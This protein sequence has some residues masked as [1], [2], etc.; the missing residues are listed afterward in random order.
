MLSNKIK[1]ITE[2]ITWNSL[3]L[4]DVEAATLPVA[5]TRKDLNSIANIFYVLEQDNIARATPMKKI[6]QN[7]ILRMIYGLQNDV[8]YLL[9]WLIE[10]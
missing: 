4:E 8:A 7:I 3:V 5:L 10:G 1:K 9:Q 6:H 2:E